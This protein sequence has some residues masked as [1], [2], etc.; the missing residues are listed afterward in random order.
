MKILLSNDDGIESDGL[1]TLAAELRKVAQVLV[2]A[3][4][5][6]Q[7]GVGTAISLKRNIK[8]N[9]VESR[10]EGIEAYSVE[11]TPADSVIIAL[12]SLFPGEID[13]VVSGIN[14]GSNMGHDVFVSGTMGAAIQGYLHGIPSIAAS[15]NGYDGPLHFEPCARIVALLASRIRDGLLSEHMLLNINLPNLPLTELEGIEIT[16]QSEKSYCDSVEQ[17][18]EESGYYRIKR[19]PDLG[20]GI[21]GSDLWALQQNKISVTPLLDG[22]IANSLKDRLHELLPDLHHQLYK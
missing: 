17:D 11:G 1:W 9:R 18:E 10:L 4:H 13:L 19:L 6:E 20:T 15:L 7:S 14:R 22:T 12:Q 3:P 5:Q 2:M 8:V 16:A 21:N